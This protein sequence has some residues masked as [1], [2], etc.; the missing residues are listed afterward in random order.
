MQHDAST[1]PSI[2]YYPYNIG[3]RKKIRESLRPTLKKIVKMSQRLTV[4]C[5]KTVSFVCKF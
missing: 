5:L 4:N 1:A 2:P 3:T